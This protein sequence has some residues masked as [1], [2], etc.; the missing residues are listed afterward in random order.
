[1]RS[2][3]AKQQK[4]FPKIVANCLTLSVCVFECVIGRYK[5]NIHINVHIY[6]K[7]AYLPEPKERVRIRVGFQNSS[8]IDLNHQSKIHFCTHNLLRKW[9]LFLWSVI[10]FTW[11]VVCIDRFFFSFAGCF[12]QA[13]R[14]KQF[15]KTKSQNQI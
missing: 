13:M 3:S 10:D 5:C 4:H 11:L 6:R 9:S 7:K 15:N 1:M 2:I 8:Y 12:C 14:C